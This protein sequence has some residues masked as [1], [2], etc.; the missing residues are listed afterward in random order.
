M[1]SMICSSPGEP[2][3]TTESTCVSPRIKSPEPWRRGRT[4][5]SAESARTSS[6]PLPSGR[7]PHPFFFSRRFLRVRGFFVPHTCTAGV[8]VNG[9]FNVLHKLIAQEYRELFGSRQK[10]DGLFLAAVGGDD[11]VLQRYKLFNRGKAVLCYG[12]KV[13]FGDFGGSRFAHIDAVARARDDKIKFGTCTLLH[14]RIYGQHAIFSRNAYSCHRSLPRDIG[15]RE[16]ERCCGECCNIR[17]ILVVN[18]KHGQYDLHFI[19]HTHIK[20][21][22]DCAV[23]EACRQGCLFRWPAL[24]LHKARSE[25]FTCRI[26]SLFVFY[27]QRKKISAFARRRIHHGGG[28]HHGIADAYQNRAGCLLG[29]VIEGDFYIF[30]SDL[31]RILLRIFHLLCVCDRAGRTVDTRAIRLLQEASGVLLL[32]GDE[33]RIFFSVRSG[34]SRAAL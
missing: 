22:P 34:A 30:A 29:P 3:V 31:T 24:A 15:Q 4:A 25:Y 21:R 16:R 5:T 10:L 32:T 27:G 1:P 26:V 33:C 2:R 12:R 20:A 7:S 18:R 11:F 23:Y 19:S 14:G 6:G 13:A 9:F 17:I 28:K 8:V